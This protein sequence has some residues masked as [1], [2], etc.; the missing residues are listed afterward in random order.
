[1]TK[2]QLLVGTRGTQ[3]LNLLC[4]ATTRVAPA[5]N[6]RV[7]SAD[8]ISVEESSGPD[9]AG[10]ERAP[11]NTDE[12]PNSVETG[13][14]VRSA[15]E[16]RRDGADEQAADE[17]ETGSKSIA[18]RAGNSSHDQRSRQR[19]DVRVCD[20]ILRKMKIFLDT[21]AQLHEC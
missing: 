3:Q 21:D 16:R 11:E 6:Q 10:N 14:V 12:E 8:D 2:L 4:D 5:S 7:G 19:D 9:L 15:S 20:F 1:M 13:G 17:D 18:E